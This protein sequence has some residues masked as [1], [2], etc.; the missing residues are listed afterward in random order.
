MKIYLK[1]RGHLAYISKKATPEFWDDHWFNDDLRLRIIG[2]RDESLFLPKIKKYLTP[3]SR[4]LEGGCGIGH[5]VYALQYNGFV[6][7]GIDFAE[8][9]VNAVKKAVPELDIRTG[10]VF[11]LPFEDN[12]FDGYVS[13]GVIEHFYSGYEGIMSEMARVV[14]PGGYLFVSFPYMSALRKTKAYLGRYCTRKE[15]S[16]NEEEMFYQFALNHRRVL[17]DL[18]VKG[19]EHVE[20]YPFD[21]IKGF[22]DEIPL[23]KPYLQNIYDG[24]GNQK[25]V[26]YYHRFFRIFAAH[27]MML[28]MK[29]SE[30]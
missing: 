18:R 16:E 24:K 8:K 17:S 28:I 1:D 21:G 15:L 29:R 20:C 13:V 12:S 25:L 6:A 3:G 22:K 5:I 14:K 11:S 2:G 7:T 19:F 10:N 4:I 23:F 30:R 9:T 27:C 26:P